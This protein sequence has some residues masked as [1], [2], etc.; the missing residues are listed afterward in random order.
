MLQMY[1]NVIVS[2]IYQGIILDLARTLLKSKVDYR[3]HPLF[4]RLPNQSEVEFLAN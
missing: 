3:Y 1:T 4:Q 2:V